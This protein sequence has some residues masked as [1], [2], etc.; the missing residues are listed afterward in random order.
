MSNRGRKKEQN[1]R[2]CT[3]SFRIWRHVELPRTFFLRCCEKKKYLR[4]STLRHT[5]K[6][7]INLWTSTSTHLDRQSCQRDFFLA[8]S[9]SSNSSTCDFWTDVDIQRLPCWHLSQSPPEYLDFHGQDVAAFVG[10]WHE[11]RGPYRH[12]QVSP[13]KDCSALQLWRCP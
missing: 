5:F 8:E 6:K 10:E 13:A 9:S 2:F 3:A 11:L 7:M 1:W 12:V 4:Y